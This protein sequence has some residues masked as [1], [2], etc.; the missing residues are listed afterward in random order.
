MSDS[1]DSDFGAQREKMRNKVRRATP[2][3]NRQNSS[4]GNDE[5][6][7]DNEAELI[8]T[9]S[10]SKKRKNI[11][12]DQKM[13]R[14]EHNKKIQQRKRQNW[15]KA[16]ED[17][18]SDDDSEDEEPSVVVY[19]TIRPSP[20]ATPQSSPRHSAPSKPPSGG[21]RCSARLQSRQAGT[22]TAPKRAPARR[23]P[24]IPKAPPQRAA[25]PLQEEFEISSDEET[26]TSVSTENNKQL[27]Q[28][29][30]ARAQLM[31]Q[32]PAVDPIDEC[33]VLEVIESPRNKTLKLIVDAT[34]DRDGTKSECDS[35]TFDF[36]VE[37]KLAVLEQSLLRELN[38]PLDSSTICRLRCGTMQL[39]RDRT[40]VSYDLEP[41][42][43]IHA[44]IFV[45]SWGS[46][47][48]SS[49]EPVQNYGPSLQLILRKGETKTTV[50]YGVNQPFK[51]LIDD[52]GVLQFDGER[53][54]PTS[55]PASFD[56][57]S[58]DLID[59]L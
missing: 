3:A 20:R 40:A 45:T 21:S 42:T 19:K 50:S 52:H 4:F 32:Q 55:T 33:E 5:S 53:V 1:D 58:D 31:A 27:M 46:K 18:S 28:L 30:Q 59:I 25:T 8:L 13:A 57:E 24:P 47:S 48:K 10:K 37:E 54:S 36:P 35:I 26:T 43:N 11:S 29:R 15:L 39:R 7:D 49:S 44:L 16:K 56:M 6:D 12:V 2:L 38:L 22:A 41:Q 14:L 9:S 23:P 51:Q 17:S 34:I